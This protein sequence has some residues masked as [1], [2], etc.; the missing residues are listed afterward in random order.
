MD[1][2]K[3]NL[4]INAENKEKKEERHLQINTQPMYVSLLSNNK[5]QR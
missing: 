1:W 3:S 2:F 5:Q 4:H